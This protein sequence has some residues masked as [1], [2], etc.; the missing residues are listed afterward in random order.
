MLNGLTKVNEETK[1]MEEGDYDTKIFEA[2]NS[3]FFHAA[4][5]QFTVCVLWLPCTLAH[6]QQLMKVP[7]QGY[8]CRIFLR[9][10]S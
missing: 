4:H 6:L 3:S 5:I 8:F 10:L 7:A 2:R 1:R 9:L